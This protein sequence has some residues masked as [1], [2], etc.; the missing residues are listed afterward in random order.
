MFRLLQNMLGKTLGCSSPGV[1]PPDLSWGFV[2][3][4]PV[5]PRLGA[6][7]W[8][9]RWSCC[10]Q[11]PCAR[12]CPVGGSGILEKRFFFFFSPS[13]GIQCYSVESSVQVEFLGS[14]AVVCLRLKLWPFSW[15]Q[16]WASFSSFIQAVLSQ[17]QGAGPAQLNHC[18]QLLNVSK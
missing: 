15:K 18:S 17:G 8:R 6:H 5:S 9:W 16:A 13:E 1:T 7:T 3:A 14:R 10:W 4:P 11:P 2:A 12:P